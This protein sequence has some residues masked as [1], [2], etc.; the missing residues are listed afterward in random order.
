MPNL[1]DTASLEEQIAQ[2]RSYLSRRQAI[3]VVD[4][5]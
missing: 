3:H 1:N 2:W 4:V 5:A